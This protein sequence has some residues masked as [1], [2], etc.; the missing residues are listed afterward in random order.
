MNANTFLSIFPTT[1]NGVPATTGVGT[2]F[3]TSAY[4]IQYYHGYAVQAI[5][6]GGTRGTA[7]IQ[8]SNDGVNFSTVTGST[9]VLSGAGNF[10]WN[11]TD[12]YYKYA[13]FNWASTGAASTGTM[14]IYFMAKGF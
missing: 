11:V 1:S 3:S 7:S 14:S 5:Y 4:N 9:Q 13:Q 10:I 6:T 2:N 8:V 12:A